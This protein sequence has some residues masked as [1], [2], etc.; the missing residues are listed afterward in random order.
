[1]NNMFKFIPINHWRFGGIH[2]EIFCFELNQYRYFGR[3]QYTLNFIIIGLGFQLRI[4]SPFINNKEEQEM[5]E[6]MKRLDE[7][8]E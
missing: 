6:A 5:I 2:V 8:L 7:E 4:L 3:N 1:M